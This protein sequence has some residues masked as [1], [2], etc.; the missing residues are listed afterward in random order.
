[1]QVLDR[2]EYV[3]DVIMEVSFVSDFSVENA[4]T[5]VDSYLSIRPADQQLKSSMVIMI[6][7]PNNN[8]VSLNSYP[9]YVDV[10]RP[11]QFNRRWRWSM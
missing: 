7:D 2:H 9:V 5:N 6:V 4:Q 10:N 8:L 3:L 11:T 1:M